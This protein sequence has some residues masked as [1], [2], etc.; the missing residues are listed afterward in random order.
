MKNVI[1]NFFYLFFLF[2]DNYKLMLKENK[3]IKYPITNI[4][5]SIIVFAY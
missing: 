2:C 5:G 3:K 1:W 4:E